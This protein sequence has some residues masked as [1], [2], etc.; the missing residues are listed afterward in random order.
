MK[1]WQGS[2]SGLSIPLDDSVN[3]CEMFVV[4]ERE[5]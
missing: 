3:I 1:C 4:G 5:L 2:P